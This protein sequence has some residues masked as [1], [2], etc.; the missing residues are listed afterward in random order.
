MEGNI[1]NPGHTFTV[2]AA[3]T[4]T[5]GHRAEIQETYSGA[6]CVSQ[7]LTD[8]GTLRVVGNIDLNDKG[9]S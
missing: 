1:S 5:D 4:G 8:L 2:Q 7:T 3:I 6:H 9:S